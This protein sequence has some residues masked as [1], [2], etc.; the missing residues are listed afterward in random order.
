MIL[1]LNGD[2]VDELKE[3]IELNK[4]DCKK[5]RDE[6]LE[7]GDRWKRFNTKL[8]TLNDI[9]RFLD[10][11]KDSELQRVGGLEVNRKETNIRHHTDAR[12]KE[13]LLSVQSVQRGQTELEG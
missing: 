1:L 5:K 11:R 12:K 9:Q 3:Y 8:E 13:R 10:T 6:S 7:G 4:L 2:E